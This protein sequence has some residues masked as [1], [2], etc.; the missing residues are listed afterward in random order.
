MAYAESKTAYDGS[1][2]QPTGARGIAA[3]EEASLA[4]PSLN[5]WLVALLLV[6]TVAMPVYAAQK[7]EWV[8][9]A[10]LLWPIA[11]A[12]LTV[13]WL[14]SRLPT[15][16]GVPLG[17][18]CGLGY[19][20]VEAGRLLPY[21]RAINYAT[22]SMDLAWQLAGGPVLRILDSKDLAI[23]GF[24]ERAGQNGSSF[25][26][27]LAVW[28]ENAA[29]GRTSTDNLVFVAFVALAAWLVAFW[30]AW[31]VYRLQHAA[32]AIVPPGIA[33]IAVTINSRAGIGEIIA[34]SAVALL[35]ALR[36]NLRRMLSGWDRQGIDYAEDIESDLGLIAVV[37]IAVLTLL[38]AVI[39]SAS[40]NP[41]SETFWTVFRRPWGEVE[42][43]VNRVFAGVQRTGSGG[44]ERTDQVVLGGSIEESGRDVVFWL[45]TDEPPP[46]P[47]QLYGHLPASDM[48]QPS[49]HY[50]RSLAFDTYGGLRW[51]HS[52][53]S[54]QP[55]QAGQ[56]VSADADALRGERVQQQY[57]IVT[58]RSQAILALNQPI[59]ADVSYQV[60]GN[61][62]D[63][64]GLSM[65]R[66]RSRYQV[67]SVVP[68]PTERELRR[69]G[70]DYPSWVRHYLELPSMPSRV[71]DLA[72]EV[73]SKASNPYDK[74]KA[75]EGYLRKMDYSGQV[76]PPPEGR[77][78]VDYFLF[79]SKRGY[80]DY[81]ASAMVVMLRAVD[82]PARLA[83][84]YAV[85]DYDQEQEAYVGRQRDAHS[86]PEAYFSGIGWIEFEP[87][88]SNPVI[89][90]P[91]DEADVL[92]ALPEPDESKL[93]LEGNRP[94]TP[95]LPFP[96]WWLS[97]VGVGALAYAIS[98]ALS[99]WMG[100]LS[101][102]EYARLVYGRLCLY[103]GWLGAQ[104]R[105]AQTAYEYASDLQERL[106]GP[107]GAAAA[108]ICDAYVRASYSGRGLSQPE[109]KRLAATW[110]RV[111]W[112][113]WRL[114]WPERPPVIEPKTQ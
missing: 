109:R 18:L 102:T 21:P 10:Q 104:R 89:A 87:T 3:G 61:G 15:L 53:Y 112:K 28:S 60:I 82:V 39:P 63:F 26:W 37:G 59:S 79:D 27:H 68:Q 97:P 50:L 47:P 74:A 58:P 99:W 85:G 14:A 36:V 113:L 88:P 49:K 92:D 35:L 94:R 90:R 62:E 110:H 76:V 52:Q 105:P 81:F 17:V 78:A 19:V 32:L 69:A 45:R 40:T 103:G 114:R 5:D 23:A 86:W 80:C 67:A 2:A 51:H 33:L 72:R 25:A 42:G 34:F 93:D 73:T 44:V 24:L 41:A 11:L 6:G 55:R 8:E 22:S 46:I 20:T 107:L 9:N 71:A 98:R 101:A 38:A 65:D 16:A 75:I 57:E 111:R 108:S 56:N 70:S 13:G 48:P 54:E 31:C 43:T 95:V 84:G 4:L 7:A 91:V 96:I 106:R 83:T 30:A 1:S 100:R 64:I 66:V 12:A 29:N 77:D